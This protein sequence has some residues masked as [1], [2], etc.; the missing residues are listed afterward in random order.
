MRRCR[1]CLS[2]PSP[3]L[4]PALGRYKLKAHASLRLHLPA[5]VFFLFDTVLS[6]SARPATQATICDL[7]SRPPRHTVVHIFSD[8]AHQL[9]HY[10]DFFEEQRQQ[11]P[12]TV[13]FG[14]TVQSRPTD[15]T[16]SFV[17]LPFARPL[18]RSSIS[19]FMRELWTMV[20]SDQFIGTTSSTVSDLVRAYREAVNLPPNFAGDIGEFR[21]VTRPV[22]DATA[23][24]R[25]LAHMAALSTFDDRNM[26]MT[27][28]QRELLDRISGVE[29]KNTDAF[30]TRMYDSGEKRISVI[31]K[32]LYQAFPS[33]AEKSKVYNTKF[34]RAI[35][36][37]TAYHWFKAM[38]E[39]RLNPYLMQS[40]QHVWQQENGQ[41]LR[42]AGMSEQ[43]YT[44]ALGEVPLEQLQ[45]EDPFTS[46]VFAASHATGDVDAAPAPKR[47]RMD[48]Q[49]RSPEWAPSAGRASASS[50]SHSTWSHCGSASAPAA[51]PKSRPSN[52]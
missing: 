3:E 7:V 20:L 1:P 41:L 4:F 24:I 33:L 18:R 26:R 30:F 25:R 2:E 40:G 15:L 49:G 6:P 50:A 32:S 12:P 14:V 45:A 13:S 11:R 51:T 10:W 42:L 28:V 36:M 34:S 48:E 39:I 29:L 16:G 46:R 38:V 19:D 9:Q 31:A 17:S 43:V 37:H 47:Q 35:H 44:A 8:D 23:A 27:P 5:K 21:R 22:N 52:K